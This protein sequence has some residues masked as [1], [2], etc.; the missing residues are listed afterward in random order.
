M[1]ATIQHI[2]A[3]PTHLDVP[4]RCPAAHS[5]AQRRKVVLHKKNAATL[6]ET[7][8][9]Q[10]PGLTHRYTLTD[11]PDSIHNSTDR[12][13]R[14]IP[15]QGG[16]IHKRER[17]RQPSSP[18]TDTNGTVPVPLSVKPCPCRRCC[19]SASALATC[20][21]ACCAACFMSSTR[22]LRS[23]GTMRA[24]SCANAAAPALLLTSDPPCKVMTAAAATNTA[25]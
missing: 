14:P 2:E 21:A 3:F 4:T 12:Y 6:K 10:S 15:D 5:T 9:A 8:L 7:D 20:S 13:T 23:A 22:L 18:Q 16:N 24:I 1:Y 17:A 25:R 11:S 19:H